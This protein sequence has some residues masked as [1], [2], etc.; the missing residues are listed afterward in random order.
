MLRSSLGLATPG[1]L[2][3]GT[4]KSGRQTAVSNRRALE[5]DEVL[6]LTA[7]NLAKR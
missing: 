5:D 3:Q 6:A 1:N 7:L 2:G 4:V